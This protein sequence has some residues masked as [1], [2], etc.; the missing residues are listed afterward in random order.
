MDS[1]EITNSTKSTLLMISEDLDK[2]DEFDE[3]NYPNR[4][5]NADNFD[6]GKKFFELRYIKSKLN[7]FLNNNKSPEIKIETK[8]IPE[9][10]Q[11]EKEKL[12]LYEELS[13]THKKTKQNNIQKYSSMFII[14]LEKSIFYFNSEKSKESYEVLYEFDVIK[15]E[16]EFGEILL[17]ISGYDRNLIEE[18]IFK[19]KEKE[20]IIKGF[21]NIFSFIIFLSYPDIINKISPNSASFFII[22]KSNKIS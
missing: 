22:S 18:N 12:I 10:D 13:L 2:I 3:K 11:S 1:K 5:Y 20:E 15:S 17:I 21:L 8:L 14:L 16:A 4:K 19:K 9:L 6:Q 7:L